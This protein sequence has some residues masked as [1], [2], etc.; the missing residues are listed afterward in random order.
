MCDW[1]RKFSTETRLFW[2]AEYDL[3]NKCKRSDNL[4][5]PEDFYFLWVMLFPKRSIWFFFPRC[6]RSS[7]DVFLADCE[8]QGVYLYGCKVRH[9]RSGFWRSDHSTK[10][11]HSY[12]VFRVLNRQRT[13]GKGQNC[14]QCHA[15][16]DSCLDYTHDRSSSVLGHWA[17]VWV[18]FMLIC[19]NFVDNMLS[20]NRWA[21]YMLENR[22]LNMEKKMRSQITSTMRWHILKIYQILPDVKL[23]KESLMKFRNIRFT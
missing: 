15:K 20:R 10:A 16:D 7:C 23:L 9:C 4:F 5:F 11:S 17:G 14:G 22:V 6:D 19:S 2:N 21:F 18:T 13:L 8:F 12:R 1:F 3:K